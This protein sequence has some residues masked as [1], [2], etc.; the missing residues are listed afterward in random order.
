MNKSIAVT[1]IVL[2]LLMGWYMFAD[3][4]K[5]LMT[6]GWS[7]SGFLLSAKTF[8]AF[9]AF[10]AQPAFGWWVNPLNSW[11]ITLIGVALLLG[12]GIR[13]ASWAGAALMILY[14]FPH[15]VFPYVTYGY[16]VDEHIV[17]AAVFALIA[18]W[19]VAQ[20]FALAPAL[21]RTFLGRIPLLGRLI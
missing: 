18:L 1:A 17:F 5:I 21:R 13:F 16:I 10:F 3:G 20:S 6:P 15:Y 14:Y 11:G 7:A 12:V 8:P 9:Y 4:F 2:R 19:P